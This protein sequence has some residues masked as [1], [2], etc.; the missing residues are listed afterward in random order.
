VQVA[1]Q[2][3]MRSPNGGVVEPEVVELSYQVALLHDRTPFR[4]DGT[5]QLGLIPNNAG[6]R[7]PPINLR[8]K[9][10]AMPALSL[11]P[12]SSIYR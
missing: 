7:A 5:T 8:L 1:P 11:L 3:M 12:S 9:S 10:S 6:P 4:C 2:F